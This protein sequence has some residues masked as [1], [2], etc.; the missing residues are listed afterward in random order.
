MSIVVA[1]LNGLLKIDDID[2]AV[3][4]QGHPLG[5]LL[6]FNLSSW[7]SITNFSALVSS[8]IADESA[9]PLS[10]VSKNFDKESGFWMLKSYV[11]QK[12]QQ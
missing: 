9:V 8:R 10:A 2:I 4:H 3:V 12:N 1:I 11:L 7:S 5:F 6:S